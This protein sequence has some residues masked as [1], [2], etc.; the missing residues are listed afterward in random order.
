LNSALKRRTLPNPAANAIS[1][2][3]RDVSLNRRL[4]SSNL[5]VCANSMGDT[6]SS[7]SVTRRKCRSLTPRDAASSPIRALESA[8]SSIPAMTAL[9]SRLAAS[10][11]PMPGARSGRQRRH[12][13]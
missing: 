12:G 1:V 4:A 2:N 9:A 8:C 13:L 6:P 10:T 7:A 11:E 5:C 3:F